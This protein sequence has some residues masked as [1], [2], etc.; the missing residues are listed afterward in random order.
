M[1][2]ILAAVK[3]DNDDYAAVEPLQPNRGNK[4]KNKKTKNLQD[5]DETTSI[6]LFV[7]SAWD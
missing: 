4:K 7:Y 6:L 3:L 2:D 5:K 1:V